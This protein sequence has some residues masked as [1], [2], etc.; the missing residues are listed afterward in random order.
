M[1]RLLMLLFEDKFADVEF[2]F[3]SIIITNTLSAADVLCHEI[4][5]IKNNFS[6]QKLARRRGSADEM[7]LRY[8]RTGI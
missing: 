5:T 6:L 1:C 7:K 3:L 8:A 2:A 4:T